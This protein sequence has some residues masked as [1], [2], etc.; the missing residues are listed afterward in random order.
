MVM[1]NERLFMISMSQTKGRWLTL[2]VS[3]FQCSMEVRG[4]LLPTDTPGHTAPCLMSPIC[5]KLSSLDLIEFSSLSP[6]VPQILMVRV[7]FFNVRQ[8]V[9]AIFPLKCFCYASIKC[10]VRIAYIT[11]ILHDCYYVTFIYLMYIKDSY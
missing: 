5:F 11:V 1:E 7:T 3:N 10:C 2:L 6:F 8:T 9:Y 4:Y